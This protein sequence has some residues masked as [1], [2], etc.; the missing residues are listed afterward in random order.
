M[1]SSIQH[2]LVKTENMN[3]RQQGKR[4]ECAIDLAEI[5][6]D[7]VLVSVQNYPGDFAIGLRYLSGQ[8]C[9][10]QKPSDRFCLPPRLALR[11]NCLASFSKADVRQMKRELAALRAG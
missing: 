6:F 11:Q 5:V 4:L 10:F 1:G 3:T 2:L 7:S 8:F 9:P